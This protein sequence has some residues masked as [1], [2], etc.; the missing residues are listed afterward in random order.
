VY[1]SK[2]SSTEGFFNR[3]DRNGLAI[4]FSKFA[5]AFGISTPFHVYW[6]SGWILI[7]CRRRKIIAFYDL[8]Y[9]EDYP[10]LE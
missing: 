1:I 3:R 6:L 5:E 8:A 2:T 7:I 10:F 9:V 4:L